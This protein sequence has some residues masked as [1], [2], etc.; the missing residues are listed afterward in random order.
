MKIMSNVRVMLTAM[1]C[2]LMSARPVY[3]EDIEIYLVSS[4]D[5]GGA[6]VLIIV[7]NS[8]STNAAFKGTSYSSGKKVIDEISWALRRVVDG[9]SGGTRVGVSAQF[10]GGTDGGAIYYP[11]KQIN[12]KTDPSAIAMA[13]S[14]TGDAF[15]SMKIPVSPIDVHNPLISWDGNNVVADRMPMPSILSVDGAE[16]VLG[17]Q[18]SALAVPRYA[19]V[20][21]AVLTLRSP[22]PNAGPT[23]NFRVRI[24]YEL[25]GDP[26][27]FSVADDFPS[28]KWS[29]PFQS[30]S[31]NATNASLNNGVITIN[32]TS[33]I[34][35]LVRNQ[36]WCGRSNVSLM[37]QATDIAMS[38]VPEVY[39]YRAEDADENRLG[40]S[41]LEVA[42]NPA[43]MEAPLFP[44]IG[45]DALS[46]MGGVTV[47]LAGAADDAR[48]PLD[49]NNLKNGEN[50]L[51]L[52]NVTTG[53]GGNRGDFIGGVRFANVGFPK[54]TRV[55]KAVLEGRITAVSGAGAA[56]R[57]RPMLGDTPAFSTNG[58]IRGRP[59]G[60]TAVNVPGVVGDFSVNVA[61]LINEIF[62]SAGWVDDGA[63][64]LRFERQGGTA[65][66]V[67]AV[68]GGSASAPILTLDV[69]APKPSDFVSTFDR[70][71]AMK[72]AI[73]T[74]SDG[75]GG[76]KN[77]PVGAYIESGLY[78]LGRP[79]EY[80]AAIGHPE[81]F[82]PPGKARYLSP[83]EVYD[84]CGGNHVILVTNADSTG[85]SY[86]AQA[87]KM[88]GSAVCPS[89]ANKDAWICS[90][91]IASYLADGARNSSGIP[92]TT[93][94]IA[95]DASASTRAGLE[96]VADAGGGEYRSSENALELADIL[97]ELINKLTTTD[98][99]M[100]APGVAVN[101]LNRF[102]HL[103]Q[104]YYALFRP[105]FDTRWEGNLKRYRLDFGSQ[106]IVDE[107]G[108]P[109]VDPTTGF[110]RATSNSWWGKLPDGTDPDD[111]QNVA[112]GGARQELFYR[113]TPRNL[114][115]STSSPA[116]GGSTTSTTKPAGVALTS[117]KSLDDVTAA[118]LGMPV[119]SSAA[120]MQQRLDMLLSGW[121]DPLHSEPR[122]VNFGFSGSFE[123][124]LLDDSKQDNTVF[125]S[126]NDGMLHAINPNTGAE[127][128][129]FMP[130]E[131]LA[132]AEQRFQG[133][134]L[135]GKDPQRF[136]Y[137]LDG[138]ITVW[139][140]AKADGSGKPEHVFLY[141]GQRRGGNAYYAMDVSDRSNPRLMW[142]IQGGAAPFAKL[143]QTWSQPTLAQIRMNGQGIPVLIFGGGYSPSDHDTIGSVS[144]GDAVGNAIYI[145]NAYN[146][147]LIWSASNAGATA[148]NVDMRWSI[149]SS[150]AAVDIDLNGAIDHIYAADLGGQIFRIDMNPDATSAANLVTRVTTLAKLGT[151]SSAGIANHRRFHAAPVVALGERGGEVILQ[152]ILGSGYRSHPLN[153]DT[154]DYI[155]SVDD[156][157]VLKGVA[158][159]PITR[160]D[161]LDVTSDLS[162]DAAMLNSRKGWYI[163]LDKGEK[164]LSSAVVSNGIVFVSSYLPESAF[165]NKCQ[166]VVGSSRLYAMN[167]LDGSPALDLDN[168]GFL[169]RSTDLILP[170]LPPSP[171]LLLDGTGEQVL[172]I[173][174]TAL[175]GG[176]VSTGKGVRKTRWYEVPSQ[177]EAQRVLDEALEQVSEEEEPTN[178]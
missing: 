130:G 173:G 175:S 100:A 150:V 157:D 125:V 70:R 58:S 69:L 132:R 55:K 79:P 28:R 103:D 38:N 17:V 126:T 155:F 165:I 21:K 174:T 82:A 61:P 151:S 67:H 37:I 134:E 78:M 123:E 101:Q 107:K 63:L 44:A 80:G 108:T 87:N 84:E 99:S 10:P 12:E 122:L 147:S 94:A 117:V 121:G 72:L 24:A 166:R 71:E 27:P 149:P 6:N 68:E 128:F 62:A 41:A 145:V 170:G 83:T 3:A 168:S 167:I 164:V 29:L 25:S 156:V 85:E 113:A 118:Q 135:D 45:D 40:L 97:S 50:A 112:L 161:M 74:L 48:E 42:W 116:A 8:G 143:G 136:T 119:G 56:L 139:R 105:S 133:G 90:E 89:D 46:C 138:G 66:S 54:D 93:H 36:F 20:D 7:D 104:L 178:P 153:M 115:V 2:V 129:A 91:Q 34:Q 14:A 23:N 51:L 114:L 57:I 120:E 39:S 169:N 176:S 76:G 30:G 109:A 111:G 81:A 158:S 146:G 65:L 152:V 86:Q 148:T 98:A 92:I 137:G 172:L 52:Q 171:Q 15:Q 142:K 18:L 73:D 13:F 5:S 159:A 124:A 77:K 160:A 75:A 162:P 60:A 177:T 95:F 106:R 35:E 127:L 110:F 4:G 26:K 9:L 154:G 49:R 141:L 163:V 33:V 102:R 53:A 11:V 140:R 43:G 131:E 1:A 64:G 144:S 88:I 32:I 22:T 19:K 59:L 96:R 47:S 16:N 31:Y